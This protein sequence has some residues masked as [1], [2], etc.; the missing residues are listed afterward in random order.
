MAILD[1][2]AN[3]QDQNEEIRKHSDQYKILA[4]YL[5]CHLIKT[6]YIKDTSVVKHFHSSIIK[7]NVV[8]QKDQHGSICK[9]RTKL[10]ILKHKKSK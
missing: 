9:H 2:I 3:I 7:F 5:T 1:N 6:I 10:R 4:F 8:D